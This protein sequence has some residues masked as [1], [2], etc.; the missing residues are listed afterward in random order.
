MREARRRVRAQ[1]DE[2]GREGHLRRLAGQSRRTGD[3]AGCD[4]I[5]HRK[6]LAIMVSA[7]DRSPASSPVPNVVTP[8]RA[9]SAA[10][11]SGEASRRSSPSATA[12]AEARCGWARGR[13]AATKA[14]TVG[15]GFAG[16]RSRSS[17][18]S[19]AGAR[20]VLLIRGERPSTVRSTEADV[21]PR[22]RPGGM[23]VRARAAQ[24]R[25]RRAAMRGVGGTAKRGEPIA[26]EGSD[27]LVVERQRYVMRLAEPA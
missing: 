18:S 13:A 1:P 8:D 21:K 27:R 10:P 14:R 17:L 25:M 26:A 2:R 22:P 24:A 9:G 20:S 16:G 7:V 11:L 19:R 3:G 15:A 5:V 4:R 23:A 6:G 12:Q